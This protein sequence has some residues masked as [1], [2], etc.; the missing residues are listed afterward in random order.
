MEA[1]YF[2]DIAWVVIKIIAAGYRALKSENNKA[3][4]E[5]I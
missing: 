2:I 1:T 3:A 5:K 4:E